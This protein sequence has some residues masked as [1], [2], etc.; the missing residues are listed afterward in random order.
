MQV[1][2]NRRRLGLRAHS[3]VMVIDNHFAIVGSL[4]L[5]ADTLDMRRDLAVVI[6]SPWIVRQLL[7]HLESIRPRSRRPML[8]DRVVS[9]A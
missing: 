5:S 1:G 9:A 3:K 4:A 2:V 6:E 8:P 7:D